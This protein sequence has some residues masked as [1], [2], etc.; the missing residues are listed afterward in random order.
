MRRLRRIN[1]NRVPL[2]CEHEALCNTLRRWDDWDIS[3]ITSFGIIDFNCSGSPLLCNTLRQWDDWDPSS[4]S[5]CWF[6]TFGAFFVTPC[7]DETI[8][9]CYSPYI[10]FLLLFLPLCNTLRRWD[11]WDILF[12]C[13][14]IFHRIQKRICSNLASRDDWDIYP[15]LCSTLISFF[16][17]PCVDETIETKTEGFGGRD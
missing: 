1:W 5:T 10:L 3:S 6:C 2:N 4:L 7:V 16:V 14:N 17:T 12:F 13:F 11:D 15:S 8:E 9:T